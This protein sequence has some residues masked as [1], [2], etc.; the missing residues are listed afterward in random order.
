ME[1]VRAT[2][3]ICEVEGMH[4]R[5]QGRE[6]MFGTREAFEYFRCRMCNC[7]QI[8]D[9]PADLERYYPPN[10][11]S[12]ANS[13]SFPRTTPFWRFLQKQRCRNALWGCG[14]K[15]NRPLKPFVSLP[16]MIHY[17]E[18]GKVIRHAGLRDFFAPILDVG[19]GSSAYWLR[20]LSAIGFR[21]LTGVDPF[22]KHD[23]VYGHVRVLRRNV[24][25]I[26]GQYQFIAFHHSLEH[27]P[28]QLKAL[29]A[30]RRLLAPKGTLLVRIPLVSSYV[31]E[32]YGVNWVEMDPP[33]HLYLHSNL[34]VE[35]VANRAGL[36]LAETV[37]DSLPSEFYGSEQYVQNIPL[38]ATNS[39][40]IHPE[41]TIFTNDELAQF[42]QLA[43]KVNRERTGGRAGFYFKVAARHNE[44]QPA[45]GKA[46]PKLHTAMPNDA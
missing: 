18:V 23:L 21:N 36:M 24:T 5:Y 42:S 29:T 4:S 33:R 9:I 6:M 20:C 27:M 2:C 7:L 45:T 28:D 13:V 8:L 1:M 38:T 19:C 22:I 44:I 43:E 12:L 15:I 34:S 31:W 40:G 26:D 17:P 37:Y 39:Y 16:E 14:Y 41:N 11:Y 46:P 25:D 10:Y 35:L 32:R 30:A 3:R